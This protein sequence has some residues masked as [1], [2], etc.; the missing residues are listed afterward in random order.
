M[1]R[2]PICCKL[3]ALSC[4]IGNSRDCCG[5]SIYVLADSI[6]IGKGLGEIP[7]AALNLVLPIFN[8]L[9][10]TGALFGVGGA[11]LFSVSMGNKD[12]ARARRYCQSRKIFIMPPLITAAIA[13]RGA[14]SLRTNAC[15][16][17][18]KLE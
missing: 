2:W 15:K 4:V 11:V 7:I 12:Q 16:K 5:S 17:E 9:F 6:M 1:E 14:W 13:S 3:T 8:V 10:G 18:E